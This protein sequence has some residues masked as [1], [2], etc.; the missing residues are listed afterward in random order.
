MEEIVSKYDV[1]KRELARGRNL[2][3]AAV[4][5]PI[6]LSAIPA[7]VFTVL[8]FAFGATPPAAATFFFLGLIL[9]IIGFVVGLGLTGFFAIR[10]STWTKEMREKIAAEIQRRRAIGHAIAR[11]AL[12]ATGLSVLFLKHGP[13]P[14]A[15]TSVTFLFARSR[16]AVAPV[17][18]RATKFFGI[19]NREDLA[20][21]MAHER[22]RQTVGRAA[23]FIRRE[24]G[25]RK[26]ERLADARVT[27][28]AAIDDVVS[29]DTD[30]MAE[31]RVIVI[32]HLGLQAFDSRWSK[33]DQMV[34]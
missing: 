4:S 8:F 13:E 5:A 29:V 26:L 25:G 1:S 14:E 22:A 19:V 6:V 24:T 33:T 7:V 17:T 11:V 10:H 15:M 12:L 16:A 32:G 18:T 20:F 3:I 30:L 28:F 2:K 9:T 27:D 31:D 34:L 23:G 21:R